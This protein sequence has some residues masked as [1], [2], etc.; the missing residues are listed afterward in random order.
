MNKT[1]KNRYMISSKM[2]INNSKTTYKSK[3]AISI[4][5]S[6]YIVVR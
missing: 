5:S 4:E 6:S 3:F 2:S 1:L